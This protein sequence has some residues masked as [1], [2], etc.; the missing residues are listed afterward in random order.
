MEL[1]I[2]DGVC[3]ELNEATV[4]A[5]VVPTRVP[6]ATW[7]VVEAVIGE[8]VAGTDVATVCIDEVPA[9]VV[10]DGEDELVTDGV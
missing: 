7:G 1:R 6:S 5:E 10:G 9:T 4:K 2:V 3:I 8:A